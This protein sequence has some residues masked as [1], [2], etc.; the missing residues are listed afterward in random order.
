MLK[1]K[2]KQTNICFLYRGS[3]DEILKV[4]LVVCAVSF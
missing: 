1:K 4:L 2:T 3:V